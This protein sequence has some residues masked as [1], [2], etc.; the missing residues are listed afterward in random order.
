MDWRL[1]CVVKW[2]QSRSKWKKKKKKKK[3]KNKGI[4]KKGSLCVAAREF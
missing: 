2:K 3:K 4:S 1:C